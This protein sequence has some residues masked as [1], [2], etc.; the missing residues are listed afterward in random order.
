MKYH[1]SPKH[2]HRLQNKVTAG[3]G[4]PSSA[5]TMA[6]YFKSLT[7]L[8][9]IMHKRALAVWAPQQGTAPQEVTHETG[10]NK[11]L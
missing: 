11:L 6:R 4:R 1:M 9:H 3:A 10:H 2:L 5:L 8:L 7:V